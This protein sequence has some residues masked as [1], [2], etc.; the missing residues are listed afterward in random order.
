MRVTVSMSA[1]ERIEVVAAAPRPADLGVELRERERRGHE[2][3]GGIFV[4]PNDD[5]HGRKS[6]TKEA[7]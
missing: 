6:T 5:F 1:P 7:E 3:R 2:Q 4:G